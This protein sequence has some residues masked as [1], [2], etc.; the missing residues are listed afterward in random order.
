MAMLFNKGSGGWAR[1][2]KENKQDMRKWTRLM[3][4]NFCKT[5]VTLWIQIG[6]TLYLTYAQLTT[7]DSEGGRGNTDD[8]WHT[9][10]PT[11]APQFCNTQI[12]WLSFMA[13]A[14]TAFMSLTLNERMTEIEKRGCYKFKKVPPFIH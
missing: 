6:G 13:F 8:H 9:P 7:T 11:E 1:A 3:V 10:S 12:D 2:F 5:L 14:F 4:I